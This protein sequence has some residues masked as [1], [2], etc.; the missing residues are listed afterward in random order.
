MNPYTTLKNYTDAY[1]ADQS[2]EKRKQVFTKAVELLRDQG[3]RLRPN[4]Q[5][6]NKTFSIPKS[7]SNCFVI[8]IRYRKPNGIYT[9]DHFL[10]EEGK[11]EI[12]K[13]NGKKKWLEK[14]LPEYK[15]AHKL[16][17]TEN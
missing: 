6:V 15:G 7:K 4:H 17:I 5:I 9:E 12:R 1:Y 10:F 16:Q 11:F 8:G 3:V 13:G 2:E 14:L